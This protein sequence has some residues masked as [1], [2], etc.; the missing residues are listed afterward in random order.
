MLALAER[1]LAQVFAVFEQ[2][3]ER[4]EHEVRVVAVGER[5]LQRVEAQLARRL[6]RGDFAVDDA[7][8]K[9]ER[10]VGERAELLASSRGPCACRA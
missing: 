2:Q 5:S 8:G 6:E 4:E 1:Q 9:V 7:V 3:V 10:G